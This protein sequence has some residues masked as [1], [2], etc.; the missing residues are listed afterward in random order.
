MPF[1]RPG[2]CWHP[3]LFSSNLGS[4]PFEQ[5]R[6]PRLRGTVPC[7]LLSPY[8]S[9]VPSIIHISPCCQNLLEPKFEC[10]ARHIAAGGP[11]GCSVSWGQ[12]GYCQ[13]FF[14]M[15]LF[16]PV[17]YPVALRFLLKLMSSRVPSLLQP[18][19]VEQEPRSSECTFFVL[20][21][22]LT[23]I[24]SPVSPIHPF[25]LWQPPIYPLCP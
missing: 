15:S 10:P 7:N 18:S 8:T 2:P 17:F 3:G 6:R 24:N 4:N 20:F 5:G 25:P 19:N 9:T 12:L 22:F 23:K 13:D 1:L 14:L 21:C 16:C 11:L